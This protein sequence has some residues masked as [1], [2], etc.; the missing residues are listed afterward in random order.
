MF[1]FSFPPRVTRIGG[2]WELAA[3]RVLAA[4]I[5]SIN[6]HAGM[7]RTAA[8]TARGSRGRSGIHRGGT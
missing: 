3:E 7:R 8:W 2:Q 4:S 1:I 5:G 6:R